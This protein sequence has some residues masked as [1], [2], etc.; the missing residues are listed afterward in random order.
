MTL[1]SFKKNSKKGFTLVELMVTVTIMTIMTAVVLF[2]YNSFNDSS[3]LNAFAYDLSLTI[4]QAQVYGVATRQGSGDFGA[5]LADLTSV[6]SD[7]TNSYGVH[8]DKNA[9][10][11]GYPLIM[12]INSLGGQGK[13]DNEEGD[14]DLQSFSVQR[15]IKI[16]TLC[17]ISDS[18]GNCS[19]D[20][21]IIDVTFKRPDPEATMY[22][23]KGGSVVPISGA[24]KIMLQNAGDTMYKSIVIYPTG[25]ISVQ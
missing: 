11:P 5:D 1:I 7:F 21:D 19:S 2:N 6:P 4:R 22:G 9:T 18:T 15:G 3:L 25:Q 8:F 16:K 20:F 10:G 23:T 14:V 12:Y 13:Y 24:I 17:A